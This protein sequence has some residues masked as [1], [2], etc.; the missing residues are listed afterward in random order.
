MLEQYED[1]I[2]RLGK[3][4]W[5]DEVGC[6]RYAPFHPNLCNNIYAEEAILLL[7][8]C[9]Q[10]HREYK[11]AMSWWC[12]PD[13]G[14]KFSERVKNNHLPHYGDPPCFE[15]SAGATM[16]CDDLKILEFWKRNKE[17]DHEWQRDKTLEIEMEGR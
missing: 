12:W 9:Q 8:A 2:S 15:C 11:V 17:T 16:N 7:I 4:K 1:I 3:P 13:Q 10:C 14:P 5:W 6:P